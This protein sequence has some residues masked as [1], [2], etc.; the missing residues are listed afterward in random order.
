MFFRRC[1][2]VHT[3]GMAF[4][5]TVAFLDRDLR[6]LRVRRAPP[7]RLVIGPRHTRHAVE[8]AIGADVRPGDRFIHPGRDSRTTP[9]ARRIGHRHR[10]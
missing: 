1:R 8:L 6:V 10:T 4:P 5:I 2:V 9:D 3:I 7:G